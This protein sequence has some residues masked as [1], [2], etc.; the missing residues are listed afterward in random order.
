MRAAPIFEIHAE[1]VWQLPAAREYS[2]PNSLRRVIRYGED[3]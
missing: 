3:T 1:S 2:N